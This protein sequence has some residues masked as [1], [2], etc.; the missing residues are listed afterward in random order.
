[1]EKELSMNPGTDHEQ[2]NKLHDKLDAHHAW[3]AL[4]EIDDIL[5]R[6]SLNKE[7]DYQSLSGGQKRRVLLAA[8][9]VAGPDLL[10]LDEPTNHLDIDSISWMETF[11]IRHDIT[12][13][14]VTH[15]RMLLRNLAT[16]I[17]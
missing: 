7:W 12:L 3:S 10:L 1:M 16:R 17:I 13:L 2:L 11:L 8:A 9:L 4:D 14:F 6:M 15:D 5:S